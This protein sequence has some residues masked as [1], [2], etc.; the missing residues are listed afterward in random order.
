MWGVLPNN[1]RRLIPLANCMMSVVMALGPSFQP[2]AQNIYNRCCKLMEESLLQFAVLEKSEK[3]DWDFA[4]CSF[5]LISSIVETF[6][7]NATLLIQPS[8]L[9]QFLFECMKQEDASLKQSC[10]ALLGDIA[11]H[12]AP[13]ILQNNILQQFLPLLINNLYI[14]HQ[15]VCNNSAWAIAEISLK[16][17]S[18]IAPSIPAII[19]KFS[20]ILELED[21]EDYL[22]ENIS[23]SI[24]RIGLSFPEAVGVSMDRWIKFVTTYMV[25]VEHHNEKETGFKGLC[26]MMTKNPKC[27][28]ESF[29]MICDSFDS[30]IDA[31]EEVEKMIASTLAWLKHNMG[32]NWNQQVWSKLPHYLQVRISNRFRI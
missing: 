11:K 9:L 20:S 13:L 18:A 21:L 29:K 12:C 14:T 27:A 31:S 32:N 8:N 1:D 7:A 10:F 26:V 30:F 24:C 25:R 19:Q 3:M 4:I 6:G 2:F 15:S 16:A 23:V 17:G 28:L 5:D 22:Y